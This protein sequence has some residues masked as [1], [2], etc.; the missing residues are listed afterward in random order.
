LLLFLPYDFF[1]GRRIFRVF[2]GKLIVVA[3]G[4]IVSSISGIWHPVSLLHVA[5]FSTVATNDFSSDS[6]SPAAAD[7]SAAV[8]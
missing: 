7:I 5:S 1:A 6:G 2:L 3:C 4:H 8:T